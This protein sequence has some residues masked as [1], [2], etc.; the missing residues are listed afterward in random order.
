MRIRPHR[1]IHLYN[2][3]LENVRFL[4]IETRVESG[5]FRMS[6]TWHAKQS[7]Q[8]LPTLNMPLRLPGTSFALNRAPLKNNL[9]GM[10]E[11]GQPIIS[12]RGCI[13]VIRS[14]PFGHLF[15][16]YIYVCL[17]RCLRKA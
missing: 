11:D 15:V 10:N 7:W 6:L 4:P 9:M 5:A 13:G 16:R 17:L 3:S 1:G 8:Q 2:G 12:C 14:R